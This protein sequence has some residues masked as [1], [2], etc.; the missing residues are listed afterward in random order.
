[1]IAERRVL[2]DGT[3]K[4]FLTKGTITIKPKKPYTTEGI[5]AKSSTPALI[6]DAGLGLR[7][8]AIKRAHNKAI[9]TPSRT[10]PKLASKVPAIIG[11]IPKTLSML[12]FHTR[13]VRNLIAL[14]GG[15]GRII[16]ILFSKAA[17]KAGQLT[18]WT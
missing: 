4:V 5:P 11:S 9:G 14:Y 18:V 15:S 17:I 8:S 7:N 10:A 13:P 16:C 6:K 2:P 1:M 3:L 12:G